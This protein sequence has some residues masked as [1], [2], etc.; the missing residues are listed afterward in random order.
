MSLC[1]VATLV[2]D[3]WRIIHLKRV[4]IKQYVLS[5]NSKQV[6]YNVDTR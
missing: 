5:V 1:V 3:N 6:V 2:N 4:K